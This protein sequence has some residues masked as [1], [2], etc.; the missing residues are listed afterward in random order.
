MDVDKYTELLFRIEIL[1]LNTEVD[2]GSEVAGDISTDDLGVFKVSRDLSDNDLGV[3]N[4]SG[5]LSSDDLGVLKVSGELSIND[6]A[7]GEGGEV[8]KE[9]EE[10]GELVEFL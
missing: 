2:K 3:F 5:D 8:S 7:G 4:V 6:L 10:G 9:L 1:E